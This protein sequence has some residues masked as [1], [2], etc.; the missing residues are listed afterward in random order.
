MVASS[1]FYRTFHWLYF[2]FLTSKEE[3]GINEKKMTNKLWEYGS[4]HSIELAEV[5]QTG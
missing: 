4:F 3:K 1:A 2:I 5:M